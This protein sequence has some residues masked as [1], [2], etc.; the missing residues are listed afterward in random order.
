MPTAGGVDNRK[1]Q[2]GGPMNA[3][4]ESD[5]PA[6][7]RP[8]RE[9]NGSASVLIRVAATPPAKFKRNLDASACR[10]R[11]RAALLS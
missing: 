3:V 2:T 4:A 5:V 9:G 7:A 10:D 8:I 11:F 6:G 1:G